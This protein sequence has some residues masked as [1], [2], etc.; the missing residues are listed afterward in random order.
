M[1]APLERKLLL[2]LLE[3]LRRCIYEFQASNGIVRGNPTYSGPQI[4][5]LAKD[6]LY[7]QSVMRAAKVFDHHPRAV[8][9]F[10][11]RD[12]RP[13]IVERIAEERG[14]DLRQLGAFASK[15]RSI[16]NRALAHE[17][18]EDIR[19]GRNVW[20]EQPITTGEFLG[21]VEFAFAALN[22][23]IDVAVGQRVELANYTGRDGEELARL[24][25]E[26]KLPAKWARQ[27]F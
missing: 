14:F 6:A 23:M 7:F 24:A 1:P 5:P 4:F 27:I 21:C 9:F 22:E 26:L 2:R 11:L 12:M 17:D 13:D 16:R 3:N 8:S 15:L 18:I 20:D 10:K 19:H 25:E